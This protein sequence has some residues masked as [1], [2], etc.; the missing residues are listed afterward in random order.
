MEEVLVQLDRL[1]DKVSGTVALGRGDLEG[2]F[3]QVQN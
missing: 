3:I 2:K 1:D